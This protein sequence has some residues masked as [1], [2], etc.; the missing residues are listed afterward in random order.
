LKVSSIGSIFSIAGNGLNTAA[1]QF[2]RTAQQIAG[3]N[4]LDNLASE[5][6]DLSLEKTSFTASA[7]LLKK[8]DQMTGTLLDV[9]DTDP[10]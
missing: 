4:G 10:R 5:S 8:A 7:L 1:V 9:L 6:V 2:A 3:P